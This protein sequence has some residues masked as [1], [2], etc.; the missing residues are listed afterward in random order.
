MK[1]YPV[2]CLNT[3]LFIFLYCPDYSDF[4][5]SSKY[6]ILCF[7]RNKKESHTMGL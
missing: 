6:V 5:F 7:Y 1:Q 3:G 2:N 4:F